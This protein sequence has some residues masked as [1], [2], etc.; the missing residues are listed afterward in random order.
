MNMIAIECS[1]KICS[2]ASF[3][4][5]VLFNLIET[6]ETYSHSK[7]LPLLVQTIIKDFNESNPIDTL[8]ISIGPGSFSSLR[9]S[10]SLAKGLAFG[11]DIDILGVPTL[12]SL[13]FSLTDNRERYIILDSYRDKCFI[14]RFKGQKP[15]DSP[16]IELL[17]NLKK[18][19]LQIYGF[20][21]SLKEPEKIIPSSVLIG[22]YAIKNRQELLDNKI[23]PI[24][25]SENKYVKINDSR[26]K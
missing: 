4:D 15:C 23:N 24:Y 18:M 6:E 16:Y 26:N 8:A 21:N 17:E 7:N 11:K 20:S 2:V 25:L 9:I 10:I 1:T 19:K 5:N 3:Q 14:Q 13:N 12:H 22:K